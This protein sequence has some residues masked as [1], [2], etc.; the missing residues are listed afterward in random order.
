MLSNRSKLSLSRKWHEIDHELE[1]SVAGALLSPT[2]GAVDVEGDPLGLG[3]V[4]R[5][6]PGPVM[7]RLEQLLRYITG[8]IREMDMETSTCQ[9]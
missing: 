3:N 6:V 2:G 8:R 9:R 4:V 5:C 7:Q 1:H